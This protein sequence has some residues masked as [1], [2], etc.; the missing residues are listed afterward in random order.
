MVWYT[1]IYK[2]TLI[3]KKKHSWN[4][5]F[6]P[7]LHKRSD[8]YSVSILVLHY[9]MNVPVACSHVVSICVSQCLSAILWYVACHSIILMSMVYCCYM[10]TT[11][12]TNTSTIY[13]VLLCKDTMQ[14]LF[15][16]KVS[17]YFLLAL[18]GR[19]ITYIFFYINISPLKRR[20]YVLKTKCV[21][22]FKYN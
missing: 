7:L 2:L 22:L 21:G 16:C 11:L 6:E 8:R 5:A 17:R 10:Y 19:I 15:T 18:Y 20:V 14:Y 4:I 13:S 12:I 3:I 9:L 1:F